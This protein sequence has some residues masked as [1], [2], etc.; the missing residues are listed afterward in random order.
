MP[1]KPLESDKLASP[2][3][4]PLHRDESPLRGPTVRGRSFGMEALVSSGPR[5][6]NQDYDA[7]T[8]ELCEDSVGIIHCSAERRQ[9]YIWW[10]CDGTSQGPSLSARGV[11]E[12]STR[13][14][15]RD[16][17]D[18]FA[19]L[20]VVQPEV[21]LHDPWPLLREEV[22]RLWA[23]RYRQFIDALE[24]YGKPE[25]FYNICAEN[26][27]GYSLKWSSTFMG[28]MVEQSPEH[29]PRLTIIQAGDSGGVVCYRQ[30]NGLQARSLLPTT[31]RFILQ[32]KLRKNDP[33]DVTVKAIG[34][35][36]GTRPHLFENIEG[37]AAMSDGVIRTDFSSFLNAV[38]DKCLVAPFR[39]I[40]NGLVSRTDRSYDD[41]SMVIGWS[42]D[43]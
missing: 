7:D 22:E 30:E 38:A 11:P 13:L 25:D 23:S 41:K 19:Q 18:C 12:L 14:L 29:G 17:G 43:G 32:V 31:S 36:D 21:I 20:M 37:F 16:L 8:H 26:A 24:S 15:A 4:L 9:R 2:Q 28:G 1:D 5:K 34:P 40:R 10:L 42:M 39:D 3:V 27:D 35:S 6:L 33:L